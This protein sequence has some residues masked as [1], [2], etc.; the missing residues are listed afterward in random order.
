[1]ASLKIVTVR[2]IAKKAGVSAMTVSRALRK[3]PNISAETRAKVEQ[4]AKQLGYR[5][6]PLVSALMSY[7]RAVKPIRMHVCLGFITNFPT[8]DGWK[9][10]K[11]YQEFFQGALESADRHGYRMEEFW[12]REPGMTAQRL[13]NIL[14]YRRINGLI[15]APLPVPQ[16]HLR[17]DW[18]KFSA[19]TF[20]YTLA[21]P[22]LHRVVN[23]QFR[24]MRTA[25]RQLRKL[26]YRRMGLAMPASLDRR[27][28]NQWV[29]SFLVEQQRLKA[30]DRVPLCV[31]DDREWNEGSFV[32][33]FR[34]HQPDVVISQ[35]PK[36]LDWLQNLGRRVPQDVGFVHMNCPDESGEF[37]GI[38]Q[39][40]L[41]IGQAAVDFLVGM[42][43]RNE[44][45][46][47][48]VPHTVLVEGTWVDGKTIRKCE[49]ESP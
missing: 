16:G 47:P 15:I 39:N 9:S 3:H 28:D 29:G 48:A 43:Q 30:E 4:V 34:K 36:I 35:Q 41:L 21:R 6:N 2:D 14:S 8:R 40:N 10:R 26:G 22:T 33:W 27:V 44:R 31:I 17:L 13:G 5:P 37:A 32:E 18:D 45:G 23:H 12:L 20:T 25:I 24:A 38:Y 49:A 46:I 42:L 11:S 19:V 1:M 7:R